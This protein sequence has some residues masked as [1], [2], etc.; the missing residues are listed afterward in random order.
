V[1]IGTAKQTV[2]DTR[3]VP[4]VARATLPGGNASTSRVQRVLTTRAGEIS[5]T[6]RQPAR[7][8]ARL[9]S[10]PS[11]SSIRLTPR[12]PSAASAQR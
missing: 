12:S 2:D 5:S 11:I 1:G 9:S 4:S 6:V 7:A 10:E 3:T 8:I